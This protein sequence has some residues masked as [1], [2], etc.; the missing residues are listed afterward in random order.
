MFQSTHLTNSWSFVTFI[1]LIIFPSAYPMKV[2]LHSLILIVQHLSIN[3]YVK[4]VRHFSLRWWLLQVLTVLAWFSRMIKSIFPYKIHIVI[5]LL[6]SEIQLFKDQE[7]FKVAIMNFMIQYLNGWNNITWHALL[8][9]SI[10]NPSILP[11]LAKQL[12]VDEDT[13]ARGSQGLLKNGIHRKGKNVDRMKVMVVKH[14]AAQRQDLSFL[15]KFFNFLYL[16][17]Y[18]T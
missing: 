11:P 14:L 16:L 12:R 3:I 9:K 15:I 6:E 8:Q 10:F 1:Q 5:L 7:A 17:L 2:D 13:F 18:I 4:H